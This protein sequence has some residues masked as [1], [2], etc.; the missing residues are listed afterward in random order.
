[1][2]PGVCPGVCGFLLYPRLARRAK[3]WSE[4]AV[5][6][7]KG[8]YVPPAPTYLHAV[9]TRFLCITFGFLEVGPIK[10]VGKRRLPD[11]GPTI[12]AP[13][14]VDAGDASIVSALLGIKPMYYLIRTTEVIG[15]RGY[16]AAMT[17]AIAVDEES[18]E[19]RS[20]AF[21]AAIEAL[22]NGG[23]NV[24]MVIFPQ[25]EIIAN[26]VVR[27]HDFKSGTMSLARIAARK[28][29]EPIWIVPVG[30]HYKSDPQQ[31]TLFQLLVERLGFR[32]SEISSVRETMVPMPW[33]VT[34]FK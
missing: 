7:S 22:V 25:G 34:P 29:K 4:E 2:L 3:F 26:E 1:M 12:I 8:G 30:I 23:P 17:G 16:L 19:G 14:H 28:R 24:C 15:W 21:K 31:G 33:L 27:R 11:K 6:V 20:K 18:Q 32:N 13:L 5:K 10:I 9:I